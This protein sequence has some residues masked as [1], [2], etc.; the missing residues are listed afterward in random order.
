MPPGE[1]RAVRVIATDLDGTLLGDDGLVSD[2][3]AAALRAAGTPASP[4]SPRPAAAA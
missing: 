3:N 2:G 1:A 4:S